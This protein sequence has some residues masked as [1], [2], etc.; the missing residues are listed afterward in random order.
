MEKRSRE[1]ASSLEVEALLAFLVDPAGS[2]RTQ[3][4]GC[5]DLRHC[6]TLLIVR[7]FWVNASGW[8]D[9]CSVRQMV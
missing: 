8:L 1:S 3:I 5:L 9:G 2:D 6:G 4:E 7:G